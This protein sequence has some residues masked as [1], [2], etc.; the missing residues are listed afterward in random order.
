MSTKLLW[1]V[2]NSSYSSLWKVIVFR[3]KGNVHKTN[4]SCCIAN[5]C[6][7]SRD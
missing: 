2:C 6:T 3:T 4:W 1:N 5:S 7:S